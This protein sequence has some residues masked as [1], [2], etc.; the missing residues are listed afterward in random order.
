MVS[1]G[2]VAGPARSGRAATSRMSGQL[3]ASAWQDAPASTN[4][5]ERVHRILPAPTVEVDPD[6]AYRAER[7]PRAD[8]PWVLVNMIASADG[9][10]Q[11]EGTS[12]ALGSAGDKEVF[13][14]LRTIGDVIL[15]GAG[16]VRAEGYGP[17]STSVSTRSRRLGHGASPVATIAVVSGSLDLDL[18]SPLFG[19]GGTRPVVV[20]HAAADPARMTAVGACA[21]VVVAGHERVDLHAALR[22][23]R[24]RGAGTVLCEG[25]P[26]LNGQLLAAS[27]VD[28]LCLSV[29]PL[30]VAGTGKRMAL[31]PPLD[32]PMPLAL[33]HV[34]TEDHYLFVRYLLDRTEDGRGDGV[35]DGA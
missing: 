32:S 10:T 34:L 17:P 2:T 29:A 28:E 11:V 16:T 18:D 3:Q 30:A 35:G 9:S 12:R 6:D 23:L 19:T 1:G 5:G 13:G 14:T 22:A 8:R 21:D 20:T 25:G 26:S 4:A 27:L 24:R 31:G 7:P 33:A 15:V